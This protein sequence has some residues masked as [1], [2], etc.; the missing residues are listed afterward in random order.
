MKIAYLLNYPIGKE[1]GVTR[2]IRTQIAE[3][4]KNGNEVKAFN[5]FEI[6]DDP[7][8]AAKQYFCGNWY[9]RKFKI[10]HEL[11]KDMDAY[12][13]D[14]L[15]FRFTYWNRTLGLLQ[16]KY[17]NIIEINSDDFNEVK[18]NFFNKPSLKKA[19]IVFLDIILRRPVLSHVGGLVC[20]TRELSEKPGF[21]NYKKRSVVCPNSYDVTSEVFR[22]P[23]VS[24]EGRLSLFFIGSPGQAWH[25]VDYISEL[26][27]KLKQYDFHVVGD[28]GENTENL[29]Y[30]GYLAK[31]KYQRIMV[32]CSICIGTLALYRKNLEEASPLKVR[33][34]IA[35]GYPVIIGYEDTAFSDL[36]KLPEWALFQDFREDVN[37]QIMSAFIEKMKNHIVDR[38]EAES[39][40]DSIYIEKKRLEF[41]EEILR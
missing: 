30:H 15:Y 8:V 38:A 18:L 28:T 6:S 34:Y 23:N 13:P 39:L 1:D 11:L 7:K 21:K 31:E 37:I 35:S 40:I 17:R 33:E 20:V 3:W 14:L 24:S 4:Q 26:A 12:A 19:V 10:S 36:P 22:K 32:K 27:S 41:F 5:M 29:Y 9:Q 2:K 16:K 25:G